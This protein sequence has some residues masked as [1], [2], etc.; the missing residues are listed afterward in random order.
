MAMCCLTRVDTGVKSIVSSTGL[1]T[2]KNR[3]EAETEQEEIGRPLAQPQRTS[4][5]HWKRGRKY[6]QIEICVNL[7]PSLSSPLYSSTTSGETLHM[8]PCLLGFAK[9][10]GPH[11]LHSNSS[12]RGHKRKALQVLRVD[13]SSF[14]SSFWSPS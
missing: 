13:A 10:P 3:R 5:L 6:R 11:W 1:Y 12:A 7:H 4:C 9:V 14:L 2:D 8:H